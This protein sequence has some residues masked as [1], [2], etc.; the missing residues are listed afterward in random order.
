ME[1]SKRNRDQ[2]T[3][4]EHLDKWCRDPKASNDNGADRQQPDDSLGPKAQGSLYLRQLRTSSCLL[5]K[6]ARDIVRALVRGPL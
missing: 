3:P 2:C 1:W 5:R 4:R 6:L